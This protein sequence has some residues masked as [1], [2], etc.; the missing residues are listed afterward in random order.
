GAPNVG[1]SLFTLGSI[2]FCRET[3]W[4]FMDIYTVYRKEM[5]EQ[6]RGSRSLRLYG[7]TILIMGIFPVLNHPHLPIFLV[8]AYTQFSII[9]SASQIAADLIIRERQTKTLET[10][11]ASRIQIP[12]V[13]LGK[14]LAA[15]SLSLLVGILTM[16]VQLITA[17][18]TGYT[19]HWLYWNISDMMT[20]LACALPIVLA[21]LTSSIATILGFYLA[22]QRSVSLIAML[23][24]M[25]FFIPFGAHWIAIP[26]TLQKAVTILI[27]VVAIAAALLGI[28]LPRLNRERIITHFIE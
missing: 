28:F 15:M 4:A 1:R 9:V 23:G 24:S 2:I 14:I 25:A 27:V 5:M 20:T 13:I 17:H 11:L 16:A 19:P 22:D 7:V 21:F 26:D 12:S 10:L 8:L 3:E 6:L 18:F